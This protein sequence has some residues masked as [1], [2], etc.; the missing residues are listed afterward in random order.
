M[1]CSPG[2]P[3]RERNGLFSVLGFLYL[4][5][6]RLLYR[7][8]LPRIL[9]IMCSSWIYTMLIFV[10]SVHFFQ[11]FQRGRLRPARAVGSDG[12]VCGHSLVLFSGG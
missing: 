1:C 10:F 5:P 7:E 2:Q 3:I 6:I 8:S 12:T 9:S 4:I 11:P